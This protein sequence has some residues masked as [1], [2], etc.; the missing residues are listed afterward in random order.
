MAESVQPARIAED[1]SEGPRVDLTAGFR[2]VREALP[3]AAAVAA[4]VGLVA[5]LAFNAQDRTYESETMALVSSPSGEPS[6]VDQQISQAAI[7]GAMVGDDSVQANIEDETG[8]RVKSTGLQPNVRVSVSPVE[9]AGTLIITTRAEAPDDAARLG[10]AVVTELQNRTAALRDEGLRDFEQEQEAQI[11]EVQAQ[12]DQRET[13]FPN[14]DL[15]SL[16]ARVDSMRSETNQTRLKHVTVSQLSQTTQSE[17]SLSAR[18]YTQGAVAGIAAGLAILLIFSVV[19]LRGT[20]R[21]TEVWLR[22]VA[23][24]PNV[25]VERKLRSA[26]GMPPVTE[27]ILADA[28][29]A[30]RNVLFLTDGSTEGVP[31][32]GCMR[33]FALDRDWW[34]EPG[35]RDIDLAVIALGNRTSAERAVRNLDVL[36]ALGIPARIVIEP[37]MTK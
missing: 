31:A 23:A 34:V 17:D 36:A 28:E 29:R 8:I 20:S 9:A 24:R 16:Y 13:N 22:R 27:A 15:S 7:I 18:P 10:D 21:V 33:A 5:G 26:P 3:L 25:V 6:T 4:C 35:L 2:A 19:K 12:I 37:D 32:G 14:S 30:G 11:D 1:Q